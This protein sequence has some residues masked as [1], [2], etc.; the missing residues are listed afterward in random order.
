MYSHTEKEGTRRRHQVDSLVEG[1]GLNRLTRNFER[2]RENIH[3]AVKVT[4]EMAVGMGR[5]LI[6]ND[7][8]IL[9]ICLLSLHTSTVA[10]PSNVAAP[11]TGKSAVVSFLSL[12]TFHT[13]CVLFFGS[14]G[15]G[16]FVGS[17]SCVNLCAA[18]HIARQLGPGHRIVTLLCDS[19]SRHLSKF[20]NDEWLREQGIQ[21][22]E[23]YDDLGFLDQLHDAGNIMRERE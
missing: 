15:V 9:S 19:G 17:S 20:Y 1:I 7:G 4:D 23:R 16:L 3:E 5:W 8:T 11:S 2:G 21:V 12:F 14:D 18:V 6:Q 22:K 10:V 13:L